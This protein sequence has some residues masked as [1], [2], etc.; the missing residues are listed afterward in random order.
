[1]E[2]CLPE[3]MYCPIILV[4]AQITILKG[5]GSETENAVTL[6]TGLTMELPSFQPTSTLSYID[7]VATINFPTIDA[8][9]L[10]Y[11]HIATVD[12]QQVTVVV[13]KASTGHHQGDFNGSSYSPRDAVI[14]ADSITFPIFF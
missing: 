10:S 8:V 9:S 7:I 6:H 4:G 11:L 1:M 3:T 13:A 5:R 14:P 2:K 12:Y